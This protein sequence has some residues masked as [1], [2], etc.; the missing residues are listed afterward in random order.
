M[1]QPSEAAHNYKNPHSGTLSHNVSHYHGV[2]DRDMASLM[3]PHA[4]SGAQVP[5]SVI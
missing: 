4:G 3:Q 1:I 5:E 2:P